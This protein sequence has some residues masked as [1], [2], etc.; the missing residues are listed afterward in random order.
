MVV[1]EQTSVRDLTLAH[2]DDQPVDVVVADLSFIPL[3][4][5]LD[6]LVAVSAPAAI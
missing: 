6:R 5:V 3:T 1:R 2:L 4:L